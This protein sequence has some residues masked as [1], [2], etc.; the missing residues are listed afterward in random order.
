MYNT[1]LSGLASEVYTFMDSSVNNTSFQESF[2]PLYN[3]MRV[4]GLTKYLLRPETVESLYVM[5]VKTKNPIFREWGWKI[6]TTIK[7]KC[8]APYGFADYS[9]VNQV[10]GRIDDRAETWFYSGDYEVS[11]SSLLGIRRILPRQLRFSIPKHIRF[12]VKQSKY[13]FL[14]LTYGC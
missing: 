7:E 4:S 6:W 13:I 10:H 9:G 2:N 11:V 3:D 8:K 14:F 1:T 12:L 5:Y